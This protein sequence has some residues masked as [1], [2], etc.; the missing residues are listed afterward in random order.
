MKI[1]LIPLLFFIFLLNSF[2]SNILSTGEVNLIGAIKIIS[3]KNNDNY[4]VVKNKKSETIGFLFDSTKIC[5]EINGYTS[6][7]PMI[8]FIDKNGIIK[9]IFFRKNNETPAYMDFVL[10]K[11]SFL[12]NFLGKNASD[13]KEVDSISGAT[14]S[15]DAIKNEIIKISDYYLKTEKKK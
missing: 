8:V 13:T 12:D 6:H 14:F 3:I 10:N 4:F 7:I 2:A 15:S 11:N 1:F 5:P 9:H